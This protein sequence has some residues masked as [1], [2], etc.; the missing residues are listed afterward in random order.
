MTN[1]EALDYIRKHLTSLH[2]NPDI[3]EDGTYDVVTALEDVIIPM[4]E[5]QIYMDNILTDILKKDPHAFDR[6]QIMPT[7]DLKQITQLRE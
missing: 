5:T 4:L 6:V 3:Y 2:A 7:D 1:Q